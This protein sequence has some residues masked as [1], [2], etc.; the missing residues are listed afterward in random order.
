MVQN[1]SLKWEVMD[2]NLGGVILTIWY[3]VEIK[4]KIILEFFNSP[5]FK[6]KIKN[7]LSPNVQCSI[8]AM[9][10]SCL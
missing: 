8:N 2:L 3:K 1:N 5:Q 4:F 9:P 10:L 6:N 7:K